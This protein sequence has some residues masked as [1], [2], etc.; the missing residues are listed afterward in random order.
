MSSSKSKASPKA[1]TAPAMGPVLHWSV[2]VEQNPSEA[3]GIEWDNTVKMAKYIID[4]I[5]KLKTSKTAKLSKLELEDLRAFAKWA[6]DEYED[7]LMD[8]VSKVIPDI[9]SL[10]QSNRLVSDDIKK[11]SYIGRVVVEKGRFE[12]RDTL[13]RIYN[14]TIHTAKRFLS[15]AQN[16]NSSPISEDT[17]KLQLKDRDYVQ[18]L[19]DHHIFRKSDIKKAFPTD[20]FKEFDKF[21]EAYQTMK[22]ARKK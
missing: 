6:V 10:M 1:K 5:E 19:I 15:A 20:I 22:A 16:N 12:N 21:K 13:V 17:Y 3:E 2:G 18:Y 7:P 4:R 11:V 14:S 8:D 9:D